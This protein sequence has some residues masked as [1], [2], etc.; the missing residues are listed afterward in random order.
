MPW[1]GDCRISLAI[2]GTLQQHVRCIVAVERHHLR[3]CPLALLCYP[4]SQEQKL[5]LAFMIGAALV[6]LFPSRTDFRAPRKVT[7][8]Y[9]P[10][11][12]DTSCGYIGPPKLCALRRALR[13]RVRNSEGVS[14]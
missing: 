4:P 2:S 7:T 6:G 9:R 1:P 5:M 13:C 12:A 14:R 11:I 10:D 8:F 3:R